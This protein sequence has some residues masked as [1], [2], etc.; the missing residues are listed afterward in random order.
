MKYGELEL[1]LHSSAFE[2]DNL[3]IHRFRAR[4]RMN[5]LFDVQLEIVALAQQGDACSLLR[6]VRAWR[7]VFA[8]HPRT[9]SR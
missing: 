9:A 3:R 7:H 1:R 5:Q 6:L 2:T 8:V 4:E